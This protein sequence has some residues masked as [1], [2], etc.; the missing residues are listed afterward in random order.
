M[1]IPLISVGSR[2]ETASLD[3]LD[4]LRR[5]AKAPGFTLIAVLTL[6]LGFGPSLQFS[7]RSRLPRPCTF[8]APIRQAALGAA[9][10]GPFWGG[11][12]ILPSLCDFGPSQALAQRRRGNTMAAQTKRPDVFEFALATTL[13]DRQNV[14]RVPKTL[15]RASPEPP[16]IQ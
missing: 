5:S 14:V 13:D 15:A 9:T 6:A 3:T 11:P 10:E 16:I 4:S 2:R 12:R 7:P 1:R 8:I